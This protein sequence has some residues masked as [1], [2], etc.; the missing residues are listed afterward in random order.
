LIFKSSKGWPLTVDEK[1]V[2]VAS[3]KKRI[4]SNKE[5]VCITLLFPNLHNWNTLFQA[6][7]NIFITL[8]IFFGY[9]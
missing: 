7:I 5:N 6:S 9:L 8:N 2:D 1:V 4:M 3:N